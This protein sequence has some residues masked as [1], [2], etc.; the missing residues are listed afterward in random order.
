MDPIKV[1]SYLLCLRK[2]RNLTQEELAERINVSSKTISKWEVGI[3][4][5]DTVSLY[6][7]S[8]EYNVQIQD[9]LNGGE[10]HDESENNDTIKNG[11]NFYNRLF[12]RKVMKIAVLIIIAVVS[13]FSILYTV[14]NYDRVQV[15]D[16][17]SGNNNFEIRG[18]LVTNSKESIFII[19]TIRYEGNEG[20]TIDSTL[21]KSYSITVKDKINNSSYYTHTR[22]YTYN[23]KISNILDEIKLSFVVKNDSL[24]NNTMI[25]KFID[26]SGKIYKYNINLVMKKHYS[27]N[28]IMYK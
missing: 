5:P 15:Y 20:G 21:I 24:N 6:K 12:K 1:G 11:I 10:V 28:K 25:I 14:S 16:I 18:Y 17:N 22:D 4:I 13:L 2:E 27:N 7:L 3:N 23:E 19:D 26:E 8:K 9:I